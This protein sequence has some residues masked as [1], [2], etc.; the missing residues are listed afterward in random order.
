[1]KLNEVKRPLTQ[2]QL[3]RKA[4]LR[5]QPTRPIKVITARIQE[6]RLHGSGSRTWHLCPRGP[7]LPGMTDAIFQC[8]LEF[9]PILPERRECQTIWGRLEAPTRRCCDV[10][11]E[12]WE[13]KWSLSYR[14]I[15]RMS[16]KLKSRDSWW[17][18]PVCRHRASPRE[19]LSV[20]WASKFGWSKTIPNSLGL[21]WFH[22]DLQMLDM[23]L[24]DLVFFLLG[25]H[26]TL[27]R[28]VSILPLWMGY[29]T[30][31]LSLKKKFYLFI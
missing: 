14:G 6:A 16:K 27:C 24:Q 29:L 19:K 2:T 18:K 10:K 26:Q 21:R 22:Y 12:I 30:F 13:S 31:F 3:P 15:S 11:I 17:K 25:F 8:V 4:V 5:I 23:E 1:M 20:L 7:G 28:H 9:Y